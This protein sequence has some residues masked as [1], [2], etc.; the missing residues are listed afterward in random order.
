MFLCVHACVCRL[1]FS[2]CVY[3][4]AMKQWTCYFL[5][6]DDGRHT[7]IGITNKSNVE[8]RVR[9]HNRGVSGGGARYTSRLVSAGHSWLL[10]TH[11]PRFQNSRLCRQLEYQLHT[12]TAAGNARKRRRA[13]CSR[14]VPFMD[15][16]AMDPRPLI[17]DARRLLCS[18]N[19]TSLSQSVLRRI[20]CWA[21]W[22][23][24]FLDTNQHDTPSQ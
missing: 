7:Y 3:I 11:T 6:C 24:R 16:A 1:S 17:A 19:T 4:C 20:A 9:Q 13:I 15:Q 14:N 18:T 8:E 23:P 5:V 12:L 2:V 21:T 22:V 10:L